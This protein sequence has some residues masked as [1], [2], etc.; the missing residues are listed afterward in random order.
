MVPLEVIFGDHR[1][2]IGVLRGYVRESF[3]FLWIRW[4]VLL[5]LLLHRVDWNRGQFG[6]LFD[7]FDK[8]ELFCKKFHF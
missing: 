1:E 8:F 3:V 4:Q 2:V 7:P 5:G 6:V